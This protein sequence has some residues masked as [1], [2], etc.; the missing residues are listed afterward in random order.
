MAEPKVT[1]VA[2]I[3][4][5]CRLP[6]GIDSPEQLWEALLAGADLVTEVPADRWDADEYYDPERGVPG[7]TVS[8]WGAF[9]DDIAG[10]DAPFFGLDDQRATAIDPQHRLLMETSWEAVEQAGIAPSSLAGTRTGV[11]FGISHDDHTSIALD[12]GVYGYTETSACMASGR[13]AYVL[14][15]NGPALTAD[16]AC[17]SGLLAVHMAA[18]SLAS[19]ESDLALAGG[20][21]V[22]REP[23]K[24]AWASAQGMLSP[25]GRCKPFDEAADGF[26][27]SEGCAVV[28][29]KR[30]SDA[31]RDGDRI[32]AVVRG[33]AANSDGRTRNIATPS[34]D[35]QVAALRAALD[36]SG[37]EAHTIGA[38]E[39]HGTGTPVGDPIEFTSLA[40][41][42]GTTDTVLLGS[43]KSNFGHAEAA[44][45]AMGFVKAVLEVQ[46]GVVPPMVHFHRLPEALAS[47]ETGLSV[48]QVVTPW[49]AGHGEVRR[50]AVSSYGISGTNVHAIV[51]Q[52]PTGE[53]T[54]AQAGGPTTTPL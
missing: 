52:A 46:H 35:A 14:D 23:R 10:F 44:A 54:S 50:I 15:V 36:V 31:E 9:I 45:G 12:A 42:Y 3:G 5:A 22:M 11:Y 53:S 1:P 19:G 20:C 25:V 37:V 38:V 28:L 13:V 27:R 40:T 43:A 49:P 33:T 8:R 4:M 47:V 7:R 29:L 26:V 51:E 18:R 30:L 24:N 48:P 39:A 41:E 6:G 16:T 2:V 32:L 17:S 34:V 21:E